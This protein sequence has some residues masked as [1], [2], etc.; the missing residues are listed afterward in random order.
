MFVAIK[1]F[2]FASSTETVSTPSTFFLG[3]P[4]CSGR[5]VFSGLENFFLTNTSENR[6]KKSIARLPSN[7]NHDVERMSSNRVEASHDFKYLHWHERF[8]WISVVRNLIKFVMPSLMIYET[9]CTEN[10]AICKQ[11][12]HFFALLAFHATLLKFLKQ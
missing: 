1:I 4:T 7:S 10:L 5:E 8:L 6:K 9:L 12:L 2:F 3:L 11:K